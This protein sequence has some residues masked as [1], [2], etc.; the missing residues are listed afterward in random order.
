MLRELEILVDGDKPREVPAAD[1]PEGDGHHPPRSEAGPFFFEI[2]QRK[3]DE[4]FGAGNFRA[5][6]ESIERGAEGARAGL[7]DA[8]PRLLRRTR[9]PRST[10]PRCATAAGSCATRSASPATASRARTRSSTTAT[11]RRRSH[12]GAHGWAAPP[13]PS[14]ELPTALRAPALSGAWSPPRG[15]A[16]VR[17]ARAAALQRATSSSRRRAPHRRRSAYVANG[18]GDELLYI[19]DG[20]GDAALAAR[21]S[22]PSRGDYVFVPR[23]HVHTASSPTA[24]VAQHWLSMS[25]GA[26]SASRQQWRNDVGQLRMDAPYCHRDFRAPALRRPARRRHPRWSR[27]RRATAPRLHAR[28]SPLDVVGWDG[29]VYPWRSRSWSSSRGWASV[30]LPPTWHGTF[31]GAAR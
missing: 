27:S 28:H 12:P 10:T 29:A 9:S 19:F 23:G 18:D 14:G 3:G 30:H 17:R 5:L 6:F 24:G 25:S 4:G 8:R 15:R 2:I 7:A 31:A 16:P 20:G 22:A 11:G 21:R 1:L 26:A 13:T